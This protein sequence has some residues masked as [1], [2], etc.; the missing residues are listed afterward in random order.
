MYKEDAAFI[1]TGACG[2]T[3][4]K[5][6]R[7][8]LRETEQLTTR[9]RYVH[10]NK[11]A[12]AGH[13]GRALEPCPWCWSQWVLRGEVAWQTREGMEPDAFKQERKRHPFIIGEAPHVA[14]DAAPPSPATTHAAASIYSQDDVYTR[15]ANL[16]EWKQ[17]GWLSDTESDAAKVKIGSSADPLGRHNM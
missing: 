11:P 6:G 12:A 7:P 1:F 3:A 13:G 16:M 8:N 10:F 17:R 9:V 15:L 4:Y 5:N 14:A 2:F